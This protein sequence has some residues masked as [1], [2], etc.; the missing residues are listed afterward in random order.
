MKTN[1]YFD[2]E[3]VIHLNTKVH[4]VFLVDGVACLPCLLYLVPL[5][6]MYF[7][8]RQ[9]LSLPRH[10]ARRTW[11]LGCHGQRGAQVRGPLLTSCDNTSHLL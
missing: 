8:S 7:G 9:W 11:A 5:A 2:D 3:Y 10:L 6:S 4:G 1:H